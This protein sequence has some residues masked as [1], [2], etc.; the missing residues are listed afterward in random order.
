MN[1]SP[2]KVLQTASNYFLLTKFVWCYCR[3]FKLLFFPQL[4]IFTDFLT[5]Q[6]HFWLVLIAY[7][8]SR[9]SATNWNVWW[10]GEGW[11][12]NSHP[13]PWNMMSVYFFS[14]S[15]RMWFADFPRYVLWLPKSFTCVLNTFR[16]SSL[17]RTNPRPRTMFPYTSRSLTLIC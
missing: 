7:F 10:F 16:S 2:R 12:L 11:L 3:Y 17:A 4:L 14:V 13:W 6:W 5:P 1:Q 15:S 8:K 9:L